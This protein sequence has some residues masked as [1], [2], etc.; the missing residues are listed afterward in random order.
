[1]TLFS[2]MLNSV[3]CNPISAVASEKVV[4]QSILG[5]WHQTATKKCKHIFPARVGEE[6]SHLLYLESSIK[7]IHTERGDKCGPDTR[8]YLSF[9]GRQQTVPLYTVLTCES[10]LLGNM[11]QK[12]V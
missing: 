3:F 7:D 8:R 9:S 1:M 10:L 5:Y 2:A 11:A 4:C 6:E 12:S